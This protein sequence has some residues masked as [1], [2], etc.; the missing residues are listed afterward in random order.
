L[1]IFHVHAKVDF[2]GMEQHALILTNVRSVHTTV[3]Q[4]QSAPT[5]LAIFH[6]H[7]KVGFLEME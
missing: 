6:V 4:T 1:G 2:L 5:T 3:M 7:A